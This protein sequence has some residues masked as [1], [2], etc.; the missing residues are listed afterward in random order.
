MQISH[1][2]RK[3]I[4]IWHIFAYETIKDDV[5]LNKG[6]TNKKLIHNAN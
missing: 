3:L 4:N 1:D 2:L 5:I 6:L